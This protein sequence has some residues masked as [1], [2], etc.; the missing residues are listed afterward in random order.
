MLVCDLRT[1]RLDVAVGYATPRAGIP[2]AVCF[3]KWVA[4]ALASVA[5]GA[6][7]VRVHDVA[8]TRD[9]IAVWQV[10][11]IFEHGR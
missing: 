5:R 10:A 3:R 1:I 6:H 2:A 9:A 11:G 4:A 7:M 8:A